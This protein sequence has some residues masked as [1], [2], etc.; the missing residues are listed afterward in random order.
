MEHAEDERKTCWNAFHVV[1]TCAHC[2]IA[3]A[4]LRGRERGTNS[5]IC[6]SPP[7][8]TR[9]LCSL[10]TETQRSPRSSPA[11]LFLPARHS[12]H[13]ARGRCRLT[14]W[15]GACIVSENRP[16]QQ[17]PVL[18]RR[19]HVQTI[20]PPSLLRTGGLFV[21]YARVRHLVMCRRCRCTHHFWLLWALTDTVVATDLQVFERP[22]RRRGE[23]TP[24]GSLQSGEPVT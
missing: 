1:E 10:D 19:S 18:R 16:L 21:R 11:P 20:L 13:P 9:N 24:A 4:T 7:S 6:G 15:V 12:N 8:S 5:T 22:A 3:P 17:R 14:F 2:A 23:S